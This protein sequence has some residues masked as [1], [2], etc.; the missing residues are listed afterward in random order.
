MTVLSTSPGEGIV[1][2]FAVAHPWL[3]DAMGHLTT[4]NYLAIFDDAA[5]QCF[6]ELGYRAGEASGQG[7]GWAD[8]KAETNYLREVPV[9]ALLQV[10]SRVLRAGR[11]SLTI[12]HAL[13]DRSDN[14]V[15]ATL[16]C[17]S[18]CFDLQARRSRPL[19]EAV[20]ARVRERF[21]AAIGADAAS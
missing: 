12:E 17:T 2:G 11:S 4:R 5:W 14:F 8:V 10:R 18:V 7:W 20:V 15:V 19:H 1:T 16:V 21:P 9:G 13:V 6:A 3:A